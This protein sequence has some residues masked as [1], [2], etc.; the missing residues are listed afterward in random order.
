MA[1]YKDVRDSIPDDL[2]E[3]LQ[4]IGFNVITRVD[5][6]SIALEDLV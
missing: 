1:E 5:M 4:E 6:G 3:I 2:K